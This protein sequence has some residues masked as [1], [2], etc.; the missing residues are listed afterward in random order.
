MTFSFLS[1]YQ[2][3]RRPVVRFSWL[4]LTI[5]LLMALLAACGGSTSPTSN[6]PVTLTF[7]SWVPNIQN[8]ITLFEQSH[9]NIKIKLIN[10]GQGGPEYTKLRTAL[11]AGSG[12]PDVV[13]L[14]LQYL[15]T[16]EL[17]HGLADLSPYGANDLKNDYVSWVWNQV[18]QG[19]KVYAI[20]QD[21]GPMGLLYRADIFQQY[22]LAVPTTWDQFAQEAATLH[23]ANPKI[24]LTDFAPND[25][26]WFNGLTWQAGSH[27]FSVNGTTVSVHLINEHLVQTTP[28]FTNDWYSGLA[29]GTY[30]SWVTAAWGPVFLSGIAG[31]TAG[32][33]RAVPLPQWSAGQHASSNWGGS[34]DAV[35]TQSKYPQQA[36]TFAMWLNHDQQSATMI[37]QKQF[38]FPTLQSVLNASAFVNAPSSFYGGQQVNQVFASASSEVDTTFQWSPFQ[39]YVYTQWQND[40]GLAINGKLSFPQALEKLQS[41]T[42]TYAKSQGFSIN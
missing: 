2:M 24:Y 35:T 1:L 12:A 10:A 42:V 40:F 38:L 13:Q 4:N 26:A 32:D 28:D 39:D 19:T 3:P 16:F 18:S 6:G 11:K 29:N 22:H 36:A 20:P 21:S 37:A 7:W 34:T 25:G 5:L 9:P 15:P 27:P 17:I 23:K 31:K 30:A 8:E 33:W 14:E 41:D